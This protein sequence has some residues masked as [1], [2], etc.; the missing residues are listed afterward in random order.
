MQTTE[1]GISIRHSHRLVYRLISN[2]F[3]IS[4]IKPSV[5]QQEYLGRRTY[6]GTPQARVHAHALRDI[7]E[8]DGAAGVPQRARAQS[9]ALGALSEHSHG[10]STQ[11]IS[12]PDWSS[13]Q[14]GRGAVLTSIFKNHKIILSIV[15]EPQLWSDADASMSDPGRGDGETRE[16]EEE[17]SSVD[18]ID[19]DYAQPP[20]A[21]KAAATPKTTPPGPSRPAPASPAGSSHT[22]SDRSRLLAHDL[23][24]LLT[25]PPPLPPIAKTKLSSSTMSRKR[26]EAH[27]HVP[28]P[29]SAAGG[30]PE[31]HPWC[32][33]GSKGMI[34]PDPGMAEPDDSDKDDFL[35]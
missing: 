16:D 14:S 5:D 10:V 12:G 3:A 6:F 25:F 2:Y 21:A 27:V 29:S 8:F 7:V 18:F 17:E 22:K 13:T 26:N 4:F 15:D 20:R 9:A 32:S 34:A 31:D 28:F 1:R 23:P 19:A 30:S 24:A 35:A 11:D 33:G